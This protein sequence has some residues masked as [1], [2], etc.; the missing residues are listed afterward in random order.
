MDYSSIEKF[1]LDKYPLVSESD[2]Q[3]LVAEASLFLDE[4]GLTGIEGGVQQSLSAHLAEYHKQIWSTKAG[5]DRTRNWREQSFSEI[6][7]PFNTCISDDE[8]ISAIAQDPIFDLSREVKEEFEES[9]ADFER[10]RKNL[11]SLL[12]LAVFEAL[13]RQLVSDTPP[14]WTTGFERLGLSIL[15]RRARIRMEWRDNK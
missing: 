5:R 3:D 12:P 4:Q 8:K 2:M 6:P 1:V 13:E 14:R 9:L 10:K 7:A 15:H 11:Q